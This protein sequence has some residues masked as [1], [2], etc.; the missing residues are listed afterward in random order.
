MLSEESRNV[1]RMFCKERDLDYYGVIVF[2]E[3]QIKINQLLIRR[4]LS[5][6][7]IQMF[8]SY[9]ISYLH[10]NEI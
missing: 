3:E 2:I 7:E 4:S 5:S 8:I 9:A 1:I 10:S 6:K